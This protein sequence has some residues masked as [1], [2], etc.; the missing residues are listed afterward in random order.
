M[1]GMDFVNYLRKNGRHLVGLSLPCCLLIV[2]CSCKKAP[3]WQ[4]QTPQVTVVKAKKE[5]IRARSEYIGQ[6]VACDYV[7]LYA[8]LKGFLEKRNF[9]EG[10]YVKKGQILFQI[11]K[12]QYEIAVMAARAKLDKA[13]DILNNAT[14]NFNR[15]KELVPSGSVSKKEYENVRSHYNQSKADVLIKKAALENAQL[16]LSYTDI[17]APL[18]GCIGISTAYVGNLVGPESPPLGELV[19]YDPMHVEFNIPESEEVSGIQDFI[20][21]HGENW[22]SIVGTKIAS[23]IIIKLI[24]SN[25][26]EYTHKGEIDYIGIKVN[27]LTGTVLVRARFQNPDYILLPGAFVTVIKE[28]KF[29]TDEIII[30]QI[31]IQQDQ[32]GKYVLTVDKNDKIKAQHVAIGAPYK[33]G[34][35]IKSGLK[36]G[37][38]VVVKGLQMVQDGMK[39]KPIPEKTVSAVL[40][41]VNEGN[42]IK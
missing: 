28:N 17:K 22:K 13:E 36:E 32:A 3:Q 2:L 29:K 8:R 35:V 34:I 12:A 10:G 40:T 26:Q 30:P 15:Y 41:K 19:Q 9:I 16:N 6:A 39:V 24:L 4:A 11:E 21:T 20:K 7:Y 23:D 18:N 31:A 42:N 27:S 33:T 5:K 25:G 14:I 38:S 1:K 37:E